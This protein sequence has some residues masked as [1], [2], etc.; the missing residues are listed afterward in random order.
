MEKYCYLID[1]SERHINGV[2]DT[3]ELA[4]QAIKDYA[5][6]NGM[7]V[8]IPFDHEPSSSF[9]YGFTLLQLKSDHLGSLSFDITRREMNKL[10]IYEE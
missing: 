3:K 4:I 5:E 8:E 6:R 9:V 1:G 2:F 7:S 10:D